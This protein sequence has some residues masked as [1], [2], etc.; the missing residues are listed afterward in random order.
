[1]TIIDRAR[2]YDGV[3]NHR[4]KGHKTRKR[5]LCLFEQA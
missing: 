2:S 3:R 1:M 4:S 5:L